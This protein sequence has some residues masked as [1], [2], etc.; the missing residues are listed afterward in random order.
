MQTMNIS[1]PDPLKDFIDHQIAE[2]RY[3]SGGI[4]PRFWRAAPHRRPKNALHNG[5]L[6]ITFHCS[7]AD[8]SPDGEMVASSDAFYPSGRAPAFEAC[9]NR[10]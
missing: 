3:S 7:R 1:L 5:E 9:W 4:P 8:N 2:G 10:P 6:S